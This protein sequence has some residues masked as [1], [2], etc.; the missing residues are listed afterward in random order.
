[1]NTGRGVFKIATVGGIDIKANWSWLLVLL[2]ITYLLAVGRF[3]VAMPGDSQLTYWVLGAITAILFFAS[4]LLHELSHSFVARS[5][6]HKVHDITLFIFGGVSSIEGEPKTARD[7]FLIAVVGPFTSLVLSGLFYGLERLV[8]PS[9]GH[10]GSGAANVLDAIGQINLMLGLFNMIPGFPLDG[11]RVLRSIIWGINHNFQSATRIAGLIGELVAY[12]FIFLGLYQTFFVGDLGGLWLSF[13]GWFLLNAAQQSVASVVMR[14][15]LQGV[16]VGQVMEPPPPVSAPQM[17]IAHLLTQFILPYNLR[18]VPVAQD[19][20]LLGIV[21]LGDIKDVPQDQWGTVTVGDVMTG[22]DKLSIVSPSD[23]LD[24]AM[25]LLSAADFDQLPVVDP[26][27]GRLAGMLTRAHLLR[28]LQI[29]D[30]LR[31]GKVQPTGET[32]A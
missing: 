27:T 14:Q 31:L 29:R 23:S 9:M 22:L 24:K 30:E 19:G 26:S 21:T 1:M 28:S 32:K 18:A 4:V 15:A 11:G 25:E 5:R 13:I 2:L 20:R 7:E 16:K 6:G 8:S 17:T 12:G 10:A 3:P